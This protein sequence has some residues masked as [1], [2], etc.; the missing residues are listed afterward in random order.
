MG[1]RLTGSTGMGISFEQDQGWGNR[2]PRG[3]AP[4]WVQEGEDRLYP[5]S[6][7]VESM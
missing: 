1:L 7:L 5:E 4:A 2:W 6:G 3:R